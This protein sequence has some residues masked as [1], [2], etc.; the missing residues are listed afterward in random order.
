MHRLNESISNGI[1]WL[2][3][4]GMDVPIDLI[5]KSVEIGA[6]DFEY[7]KT[8]EQFEARLSNLVEALYKETITAPQFVDGLG[9]LIS[10]QITLAYREAWRDEGDG[11][12]PDY[13]TA[14]SEAAILIQFDFVDQFA[15]DIV[16]ARIDE[17]P[18]DGLLS[19][20]PLWANRYNEAYNEAVM[21]ISQKNGGKLEWVLGETEQHCTTC[22]N[23]N[24]IV[25]YAKEWEA[26]NVKPQNAPNN[27]IECGG[28]RCDCSLSP[29]TKRRTP[30]AYG[31]I[32]E[33]IL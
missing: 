16:D 15:R 19:R 11:Q 33:A 13:L 14:A 5:I 8:A 18:I 17:K 2:Y 10:R 7:Y 12:Y 31:R 26:L 25:A 29:T 27:K 3:G 23:L 28:W 20:V 24:G 32:E 1:D 4:W 22:S 21:L 30:G 6:K 9:A